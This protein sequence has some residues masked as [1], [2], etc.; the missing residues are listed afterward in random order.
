MAKS[1]L[2]KNLDIQ[3]CPEIGMWDGRKWSKS[4]NTKKEFWEIMVNKN[5]N[6]DNLGEIWMKDIKHDKREGTWPIKSKIRALSEV[7]LWNTS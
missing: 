2:L 1:E 5:E 7:G 3:A 6:D 4:S